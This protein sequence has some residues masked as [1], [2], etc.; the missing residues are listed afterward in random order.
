V[1]AFVTDGEHIVAIHAVRN[2][3]K[4]TRVPAALDE[5]EHWRQRSDGF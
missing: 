5:H 3:D 2:P 4:L 1:Q